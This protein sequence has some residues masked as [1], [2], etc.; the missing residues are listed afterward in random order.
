[1]ESSSHSDHHEDLLHTPLLDP[2]G[3]KA[4]DHAMS[5]R[6][7]LDSKNFK[8]F[9]RN[10]DRMKSEIIGMCIFLGVMILFGWSIDKSKTIKTLGPAP[11]ALSITSKTALYACDQSSYSPE[12][13]CYVYFGNDNTEVNGCTKSLSDFMKNDVWF[14]RNGQPNPSVVTPI[15][16]CG[17]PVNFSN[18]T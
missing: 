7:T 10:K 5:L 13:P 8:L 1:M 2:S 11:A 12:N 16:E 9:T 14:C 18:A 17:L 3:S 6:A 15:C 4:S